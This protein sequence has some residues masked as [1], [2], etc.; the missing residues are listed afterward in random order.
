MV[1]RRN[2]YNAVY[3]GE[4][5]VVREIRKPKGRQYK[6]LQNCRLLYISLTRESLNFYCN[7][8]P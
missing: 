8:Y 1:R 6:H 4:N 2:T 7:I 5:E 3:L